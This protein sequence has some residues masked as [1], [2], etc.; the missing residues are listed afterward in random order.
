MG[1][2]NVDTYMGVAQ[3]FFFIFTTLYFTAYFISYI[4]SI[5]SDNHPWTSSNRRQNKFI[6]I[7]VASILLSQLLINFIQLN[8]LCK[9]NINIGNVIIIIIAPWLLIFGTL[10]TLLNMFPGWLTPFSNTLGYLVAGRFNNIN[11]LINDLFNTS[12]DNKGSENIIKSIY[13]NKSLLINEISTSNFE[14]FIKGMNIDNNNVNL[15]RLYTVVYAKELVAYWL[16]YILTG[17]LAI[18]IV[19]NSIITYRC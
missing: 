6:F 11:Q 13:E 17:S 5:S 2:V 12:E 4:W 8:N 3:L 9:G 19:S 15:R 14:T 7:Y 10:V 16:W 1:D 18:S